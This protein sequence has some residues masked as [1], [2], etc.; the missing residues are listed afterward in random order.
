[1]ARIRK[2]KLITFINVLL[3][4]FTVVVLLVSVNLE[5]LKSDLNSSLGNV[6]AK[7]TLW[8]CRLNG[9]YGGMAV[10]ETIQLS[11][12]CEWLG[13]GDNVFCKVYNSS[14]LLL[15][16]SLAGLITTVFNIVVTLTFACCVNG[17]T[18]CFR[19]C[20]TVMSFLAFGFY[21]GS[22]IQYS[23][24]V[25]DAF[26]VGYHSGWILYLIGCVLSLVSVVLAVFSSNVSTY[27]FPSEEFEIK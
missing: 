14:V 4:I 19:I 10:D 27:V 21:A 7:F 13:G 5:W 23:V 12:M 15:Y 25:E 11:D 8:D 2:G 3:I 20:G 9:M 26:D 1:M 17:G 18:T 16:L 6:E 24:R 22:F